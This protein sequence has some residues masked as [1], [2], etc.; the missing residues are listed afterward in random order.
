[1]TTRAGGRLQPRADEG[2]AEELRA[3]LV[4]DRASV[5][6]G[7]AF[8][9]R[10]EVANTS[11]VI[12][13][14]SVAVNGLPGAVVAPTPASLALFPGT[15]G[16][17]T[18]RIE[19]PRSFPAGDRRARVVVRSSVDP[20]DVVVLGLA[21]EVAAAP[22]AA[23]SVRPSVQRGHGKGRFSVVCRNEG[24]TDLEVSLAASDPERA[25]RLGFSPQSLLVSR[26][27]WAESVLSVRAP[28]HVFG[29][30]RARPLNV[31]A[32]ARV[33][34]PGPAPGT[35][36]GPV[37][38]TATYVQRP[39]VP[40]GVVTA[41]ALAGIV[42]LWAAIF[43]LG[44]REVLAQQP[45]TKSAPLSFF[46]PLARSRPARLGGSSTA[47][48]SEAQPKDLAPLGV[49]GTISGTVTAPGEPGGAGQVTVQAF[50]LGAS[51]PPVS[52]ATQS[53]GTYQIAGLFPGSYKVAFSGPGFRT[54]WYPSATS[55]AR[56][57]VVQVSAEATV[58][59]IDAVITGLPGSI[60]GQVLTGEAPSPPVQVSVL[61]HGTPVGVTAETG[62]TGRYDLANL[63]APASYTLRF[64]APGFLQSDQRVSVGPGQHVVANL[65]QLQAG[66]GQLN[67]TVTDGTRPLGGVTVTASA[68]GS[69]YLS[70]SATTGPAGRFSFP[71][72]P[73]PA[74]YL[75]VFSKAGFGDQDVAVDLGPGQVVDN[76]KV[77]LVGGSGTISGTVRGPDGAPLG[78]VT[79]TV[80]GVR[81]P[82]TTQTLTAGKVGSYT[83][84]GLPTPGTYAV[85]FT[86]AGYLS[87]T[88][89]VVLGPNGLA[90][91]VDVTLG[92]S[93]GQLSGTVTDARTGAPL[94][95]VT[96]SAT[97][98]ASSEQTATGRSP[99]GG[100]ALTQL[101]A[102]TYSVT[103]S[104]AGYAA[105]TALVHLQP[106]QRA[107]QDIA[108][109]PS[110]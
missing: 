25:L 8:V 100:Y 28:R 68:N 43:T 11:A 34:G 101:P 21:L 59:N 94:I 69:T 45:L 36:L 86:L 32:N 90:T 6:P 27:G 82:V 40:R 109:E 66:P 62:P 96:V 44:L 106:G 98:G 103:F 4:P 60:V 7:Q 102:G 10:V 71:R 54:L 104:Y 63:P 55:A 87:K 81:A 48:P 22:K 78:G 56:A 92:K 79:V 24:N 108:L 58:S 19:L 70:A 20:R 15:S 23:L 105:E 72:L 42:A 5:A 85:S 9:T 91:G 18:V 64:K 97:D 61:A 76:L 83:I 73:T 37:E 93:L 52:A 110:P 80:G 88:V 17:V 95:G 107:V 12:D 75:L 26:A 41:L 16:S 13:S 57:S 84:S 30:E 31:V 65:V 1:V 77:A 53:D 50:L 74:T 3:S 2:R 39:R 47:A 35:A 89:G 29:S 99:A 51:G 67:G 38:A 49:G 33:H 46:A 14:V